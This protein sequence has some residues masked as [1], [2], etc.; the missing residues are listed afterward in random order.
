MRRL[1]LV[2][3]TA[4][5]FVLSITASLQAQTITIGSGSGVSVPAG[6]TAVLDPT[7]EVSLD[8]VNW[9]PVYAI[10]WADYIY[11]PGT[12]INY[13]RPNPNPCCGPDDGW[14][15]TYWYRTT[16]T[17][18]SVPASPSIFGR[19]IGDDV[20]LSV[21][22]NGHT[23][24]ARDRGYFDFDFGLVYDPSPMAFA[25][26]DPAIFRTGTNVIEYS[27]QNL[28]GITSASFTA[29]VAVP[30]A[31]ATSPGTNVAVQPTDSTTGTT[32]PISL[33]FSNVTGGGTTTVTSS[34][35]GAPPP[36]GFK[37]GN[38]PTY[39]NISSTATFSGSVQLCIDYSGVQ[40][41]N[42]ST[43]K[44]MHFTGGAWVDVTTSNDTS[45]NVIC[46]TTPHFSP[47][48]VVESRY[49]ASIQSP[50][51]ADGS[52]VFKS[53]RGSIPVKFTATRDGVATCALPAATIGV[54][55]VS[56]ATPEAVAEGDYTMPSDNGSSFRS[57]G[58]QYVYNLSSS[59]GRGTYMVQIE[60]DGAA[61]GSAIFGLQ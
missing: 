34:S 8:R 43:L 32:A 7:V 42:A 53:N 58:C 38:P 48:V 49:S 56:S 23:I 55:R 52:S 31:G 29:T 1:S 2:A 33:T 24:A 15:T 6:G 60:I 27:V 11:P 50:I 17:L 26:T 51:N 41:S 54:T 35:G 20:P 44:L 37:L 16:F 30:T 10:S 22:V 25:S 3:A 21:S 57:S 19:L 39:Y 46:G 13:L 40:Y 14:D 45:R 36:D 4:V 47:F 5:C 12:A 18:A 28:G 9:L 61:V 59:L